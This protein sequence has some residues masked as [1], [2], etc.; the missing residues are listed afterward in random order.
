MIGK[1]I[2]EVSYTDTFEFEQTSALFV[3]LF[4]DDGTVFKAGP[5]SFQILKPGEYCA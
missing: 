5:N 4:C 3:Y 2:I 1:R